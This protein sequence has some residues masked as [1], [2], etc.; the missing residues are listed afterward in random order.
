V[1][2]VRLAGRWRFELYYFDFS[3]SV[4]A[5]SLLLA[6]TA[7]S[8]GYD[9]FTFMD[10]VMRASRHSLAYA[11]AAGVICNLGNMLLVA[12]VSLVGMAI[13]FPVGFG[14]AIVVASLI[15]YSISPTGN[16]TLFFSGIAA[17]VLAVLVCGSGYR[18]LELLREVEKMKAG[19][20]RTLRPA[21][22]WKGVLLSVG[23]G[24]VLGSFAPVLNMARDPEI[25]LGPYSLGVMVCVGMAA[26]TFIYNMYFMNLP[27]KGEP[28]EILAYFYGGIKNHLWGLA[29]GVVWAVGTVA[30]LVISSSPEETQPSPVLLSIL[31]HTPALLA[32][33]CGLLFWKELRGADS[34]VA[35]QIALMFFLFLGGVVLLAIAPMYLSI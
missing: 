21:V 30:A 20:H 19:L 27:V 32:A 1:N 7:G 26:S 8:M 34:K 29:G 10:D 24:L 31:T 12:G 28:V 9:S 13:A 11:L 17:I 25:G 18:S 3:F 14:V 15:A 2:S 5:A 4:V 23:G 33:L 6:F 35:A 16:P 22:S